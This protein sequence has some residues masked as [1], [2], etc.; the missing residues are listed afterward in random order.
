MF[1]CLKVVCLISLE[2]L[3]RKQ[4]A[5]DKEGTSPNDTPGTS[6]DRSKYIGV[7]STI[8][9]RTWYLAESLGILVQNVSNLARGEKGC[10]HDVAIVMCAYNHPKELQDVGGELVK[11][12]VSLELSNMQLQTE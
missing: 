2:T 3:G 5:Q 12:W 1:G 7:L 9:H 8:L 10:R 11:S 6:C 4:Y